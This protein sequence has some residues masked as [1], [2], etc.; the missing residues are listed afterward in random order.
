MT[1][2]IFFEVK[3]EDKCSGFP[4]PPIINIGLPMLFPILSKIDKS[5]PAA[6]PSLSI[7][8]KI[9]SPQLKVFKFSICFLKVIFS[10]LVPQLE[11]N[12]ISPFIFY[13][14]SLYK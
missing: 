5:I 4:A 12:L 1:P 6:F 9:I 7:E 2:D 14:L 13:D 3:T 10:N 11:Y 8:F